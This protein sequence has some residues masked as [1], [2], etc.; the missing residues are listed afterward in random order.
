MMIFVRFLKIF[1]YKFSRSHDYNF[2]I[3]LQFCFRILGHRSRELLPIKWKPRAR[4]WRTFVP[5]KVWSNPYFKT[6]IGLVCTYS[7]S[8]NH[9]F[10]QE[11]NHNKQPNL[12]HCS[13]TCSHVFYIWF[14]DYQIFITFNPYPWIFGTI[15]ERVFW[16][17]SRIIAGDV[18]VGT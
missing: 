10:L 1:T 14:T 7:Q 4:K 16:K 15:T 13:D 3:W 12:K 5:T 6:W 11:K 9:Y 8:K 17:K 18:T 2:W